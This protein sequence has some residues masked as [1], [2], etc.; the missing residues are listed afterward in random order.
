MPENFERVFEINREKYEKGGGNI[1][2]FMRFDVLLSVPRDNGCTVWR[3][4]WMTF[5]IIFHVYETFLLVSCDRVCDGKHSQ[6]EIRSRKTN[7]LKNI[8]FQCQ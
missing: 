6:L 2:T 8:C 1:E 5:I 3:R 7:E 4:C